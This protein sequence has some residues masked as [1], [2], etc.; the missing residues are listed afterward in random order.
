MI[1]N[2]LQNRIFPL[3]FLEKVDCLPN[4][5]VDTTSKPPVVQLE[6]PNGYDA[7]VVLVYS[8]GSGHV[9]L[10]CYMTDIDLVNF[11]HSWSGVYGYRKICGFG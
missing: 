11:T 3:K 1:L 2:E 7:V 6:D 5:S 9:Y 8:Y 10:D 4:V